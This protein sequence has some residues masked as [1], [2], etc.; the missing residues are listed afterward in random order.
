[1]R[2]RGKKKWQ[3]AFAVPKLMKAQREM[4]RDSEL[5]LKPIIDVYELEEFD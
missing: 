4:W 3:T 2:D 1:M 5:I